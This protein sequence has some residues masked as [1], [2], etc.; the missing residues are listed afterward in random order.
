MECKEPK[1][2]IDIETA[3]RCLRAVSIF[4]SDF[5]KD[6]VKTV[7]RLFALLRP[8]RDRDR[9]PTRVSGSAALCLAGNVFHR[10]Q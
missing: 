3:R 7:L 1:L 9:K 4:Y 2:D 6:A 10:R 5:G 8:D